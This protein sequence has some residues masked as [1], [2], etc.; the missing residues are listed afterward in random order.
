MGRYVS[1][2]NNADVS[3]E[4][5]IPAHRFQIPEVIQLYLQ[6]KTTAVSGNSGNIVQRGDNTCRRI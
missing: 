6:N 1:E 3:V 4:I 5:R 2:F